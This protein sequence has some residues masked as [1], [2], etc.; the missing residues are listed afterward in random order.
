MSAD[1]LDVTDMRERLQTAA[2]LGFFHH[3]ATAR[4]GNAQVFHLV[5]L[6]ATALS[7]AARRPKAIIEAGGPE[8]DG[9][10]ERAVSELHLDD[11]EMEAA[12]ADAMRRMIVQADAC[13]IDLANPPAQAVLISGNGQSIRL[14]DVLPSGKG[15]RARTPQGEDVSL[16]LKSATWTG[17]CD[18]WRFPVQGSL[19]ALPPG[20]GFRRLP[21]AAGPVETPS[22]LPG[23]QETLLEAERPHLRAAERL[24]SARYRARGISEDART[25]YVTEAV[26]SALALLAKRADAFLERGEATLD[27]TVERAVD[28]VLPAGDPCR[29][30][31]ISSLRETMA[32]VKAR[33]IDIDHPPEAAI[34]L[35]AS[36]AVHRMTDFRLLTE[37]KRGWISSAE[38]EV[39]QM[40]MGKPV[41]EAISEAGRAVFLVPYRDGLLLTPGPRGFPVKG[42]LLVQEPFPEPAPREDEELDGPA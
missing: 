14:G 30:D 24:A 17:W 18:A 41:L 7:F 9:I 32:Q 38:Q 20:P 42:S 27:G 21:R 26:S 36:G 4:E 3:R 19:L 15:L 23:V 8:M 5:D 31:V 39:R 11:P 37:R 34:F 12:V 28:R 22:S 33:A 13:A 29:E 6:A 40:A 16:R 10:L 1:P 2:R 25:R 35:T